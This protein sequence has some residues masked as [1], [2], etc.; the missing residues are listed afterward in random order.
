MQT[1]ITSMVGAHK[2][3][4]DRDRYIDLRR[5]G[6]FKRNNAV[7]LIGSKRIEDPVVYSIDARDSSS[8]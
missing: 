3:E 8:Q 4:P 5:T 1:L 6:I 2:R 7:S